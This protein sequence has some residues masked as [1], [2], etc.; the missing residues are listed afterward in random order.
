MNTKKRWGGGNQGK[1]PAPILRS[2]DPSAP[3]GAYSLPNFLIEL[4]E[5][6]LKR[7]PMTTTSKESQRIPKILKN[8]IKDAVAQREERGPPLN[9]L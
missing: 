4:F 6:R 3:I 7:G 2:C 9:G 1:D 8:P 5:E